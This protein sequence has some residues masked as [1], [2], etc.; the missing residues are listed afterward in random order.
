MAASSSSGGGMLLPPV[1]L[2]GVAL[3]EELDKRLLVL[4]R[5]GRKLLGTLVS[6]DQVHSLQGLALWQRFIATAV[7][8]S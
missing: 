8:S 3:A 1:P 4:L 2:P 5:D 7:I 6:F